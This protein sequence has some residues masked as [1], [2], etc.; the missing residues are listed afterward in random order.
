MDASSEPPEPM[1]EGSTEPGGIPPSGE[2][3][4][5]APRSSVLEMTVDGKE[6]TMSPNGASDESSTSLS[7]SLSVFAV[8]DVLMLLAATSQTGELHTVGGDVEGWLWLTEGQLANARVGS[9]T[10]IGQAV[11][12]LARVTEGRFDFTGGVVS[13]SGHPT[14]PV[15]AVLQEVQPQVEEWR[16]LQSVLPLN[17]EVSLSPSPPGQ[18]VRIRN[19]QWGVLTT[20]GTSGLSVK[21]VLERIGGDQIVG[22]RTLRDLYAAGLVAV[23]AP[24]SPDAGFQAPVLDTAPQPGA[25]AGPGAAADSAHHPVGPPPDGAVTPEPGAPSAPPAVQP[26]GLAEVAMVP[27]PIAVDPWAPPAEA[28]DAGG[29]GVA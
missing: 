23:A 19:D 1:L 7:G 11:F 21:S 13:S 4:P 12:E 29:D 14:V 24:G 6:S 28:D 25:D 22:L 9:A 5:D 2:T 16:Q 8:A 18:D 3:A 10:T 20:V 15:P 27:P 17:A 26:G